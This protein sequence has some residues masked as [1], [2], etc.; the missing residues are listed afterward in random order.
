M[1]VVKNNSVKEGE[2]QFIIGKDLGKLQE[3]TVQE[4]IGSLEH[5]GINIPPWDGW[6]GNSQDLQPWMKENECIIAMSIF[7]I[8]NLLVGE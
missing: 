6:S 2:G 5:E 4:K 3:V 8:Q 1:F 7:K